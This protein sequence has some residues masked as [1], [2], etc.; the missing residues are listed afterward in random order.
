[1]VVV[2]DATCLERNMNLVL[3][4]ME[5][6][7]HVLVCVNL[8][9]EAARKNISI[10]LEM[11]SEKLGVPVVGTIA[12]KKKSLEQFLKQLDALVDD[13][14]DLHPYQVQYSPIIEQAI[15]MAEPL[16]KARVEGKSIPGG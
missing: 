15:A 8:L 11:L 3:Q 9:D 1:M 5:I 13:K 4:T 16:V 2:C 6:S 7:D 12:R 14:K 10:D